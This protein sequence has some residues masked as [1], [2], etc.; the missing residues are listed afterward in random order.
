M[1]PF[2][3]IG[4]GYLIIG[5]GIV[6]VVCFKKKEFRDRKESQSNITEEERVYNFFEWCNG[7]ER[8]LSSKVF[9]INGSMRLLA[10]GPG[11]RRLLVCKCAP[12][13]KGLHLV[14]LLP[15]EVVSQFTQGILKARR[16]GYCQWS[17]FINKC[18]FKIGAA[19]FGNDVIAVSLR[20]EI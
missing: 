19:F 16:D 9:L 6:F 20:E 7:M 8:L 2:I 18:A 17:S 5:A 15:Q 3:L 14:D 4:L 10:A 11:I 12:K 1:S 13:E